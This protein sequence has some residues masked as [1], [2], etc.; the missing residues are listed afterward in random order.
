MFD[1][2]KR[3]F[4]KELDIDGI[5]DPNGVYGKKRLI[6]PEI[7]VY[8][9][10]V[11]SNKNFLQKVTNSIPGLNTGDGPRHADGGQTMKF[12]GNSYAVLKG[13][14]KL[15]KHFGKDYDVLIEGKNGL[16]EVTIEDAI[17]EIINTIKDNEDSSTR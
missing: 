3:L 16:Q 13:L 7:C 12:F 17:Y 11:S 4:R 2:I 5:L 10:W 6:G 14:S 9:P 8:F 1:S 15:M